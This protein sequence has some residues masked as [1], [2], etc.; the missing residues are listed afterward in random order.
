MVSTLRDQGHDIGFMQAPAEQWDAFAP[1][2]VGV[3]HMFEYFEDYIYFGPDSADRI[4]A[5]NKATTTPFTNFETWAKENIPL[6][7]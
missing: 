4:E 6:G 2:A 5:A 1:W 7:F 3:R